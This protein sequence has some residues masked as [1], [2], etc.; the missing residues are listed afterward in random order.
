[1]LT[2]TNP[3]N[4]LRFLSELMSNIEFLPYDHKRYW[5]SEYSKIKM[6][7]PNGDEQE[8]IAK[9]VADFDSQIE[10]LTIELQK[11]EWLKQGM[12]KD[13]LTGKVRLV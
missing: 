1:M 12:M 2:T 7:I 11:Y 13:L 9:V 3:H 8:A 10:T 5:I 4:S 6:L